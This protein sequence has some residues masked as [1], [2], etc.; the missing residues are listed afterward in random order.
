MLD[1]MKQK[2][3]LL[4]MVDHRENRR[5]EYAESPGLRTVEPESE[6]M[7]A[8]TPKKILYCTDFSENS[9]P[10]R[11]C[12]VDYARSFQAELVVVHV[13]SSRLLGYPF[14]EDTAADDM[15]EL[16]HRLEDRV[17]EELEAV[18]EECG[19]QCPLVRA[20]V[21][22]GSVA[23][24]IVRCA[25]EMSADLIVMGTHGWSGLKQLLLGSV[26]E[27]V[28]RMATCPVLIVRSNVSGASVPQAPLPTV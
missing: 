12:A 13:M 6:E 17:K 26:A 16:R 9:T 24:E 11:A 22:S 27:N 8:G 4:Y 23:N 20:S 21:R 5:M 18:A 10:A 14:F 28:L 15:A 1:E 3:L 7:P 19:Q 25:E 2:A